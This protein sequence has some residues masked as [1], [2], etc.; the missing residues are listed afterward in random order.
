MS[1]GVNGQ[2]KV[3][4]ARNGKVFLKSNTQYVTFLS[5]TAAETE[6]KNITLR[7]AA[8]VNNFAE[9]EVD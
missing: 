9:S 4:E 3:L 1:Q 6:R 8:P 7:S 5:Q 2:I